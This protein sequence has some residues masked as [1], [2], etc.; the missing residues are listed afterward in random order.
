MEKKGKKR[1]GSRVTGPRRLA[2]ARPRG[3]SYTRDKCIHQLFEAQADLAPDHVAVVCE[4]EQL[5]YAQLN[6]CANQLADRLRSMG[7]GPEVL[8]AIYVERS[9]EMVIGILATLKAG[10]AYVPLDP[11][12][13]KERIAFMFQDAQVPVV[14]TQSKLAKELAQHGAQIVTLD[15]DWHAVARQRIDNMV[16]GVLPDNLA[17]VIYTSGSTGNPKG[18]MITHGN[19]C[20]YVHA[21]RTPLGVGSDTRYLHTATIAFSSSVRQFMLPLTQGAT[22]VIATSSRITDPLKLFELI[23]EQRVTVIDIV[24]SYWRSCIEALVRVDPETRAR[25]L[26]NHLNLIVSASEPLLSDLPRTWIFGFKHGARLINMFGQTETTGIVAVYPIPRV[27]EESVRIVSIGKAIAH[28]DLHILGADLKPVP[29]GQQGELYIGG[30]GLGRG[31]LRR[32]E[33]TAEK[34]IPDPF[35]SESGRRLYKTGD[36][37]RVRQDG[38]IEFLGRGDNQV[39]IRGFRVELPEVE[40]TLSQHPA[41]RQAVV[42]AREVQPGENRLFAYIVPRSKIAPQGSEF[43]NFLMKI[44]PEYMVPGTFVMLDALPLT[45]TGKVDRRALPLPDQA[46]P[47]VRKNYVRPRNRTEEKLTNIWEQVLGVQPIGVEDNYFDLGGH[48]LLAIRLFSEIKKAFGKD[49]PVL[50][51]FKA[52]TI[53]Q[54]AALLGSHESMGTSILVPIRP[55]GSKPPLFL[56]HV[57]GGNLLV[58]GALA[59]YMDPGQPLYGLQPLGMNN[60]QVLHTRVETMAP[61]YIREIRALQAHGPYYLG[62]FS[63]GGKVAFEIARQLRNEGEEIALLAL[64]DT[65]LAPPELV[66]EK[67]V[68][69]TRRI[70]HH[71]R[72][73][74]MLPV[75]DEIYYLKERLKTVKKVV[76]GETRREREQN[77]YKLDDGVPP[78]VKKAIDAFYQ[79][80]RTYNPKKFDGRVTLFRAKDPERGGD[81]RDPTLGWERWAQKGVE[82]HEVPGN[83][84]S[85]I[86]EPHVQVLGK[87]LSACLNKAQGPASGNET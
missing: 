21:M 17:Y 62:G 85:M 52:P 82:I 4:G 57:L 72:S 44:L 55:H 18:V 54:L 79:A 5:T 9:L 87:A 80:S 19:V 36:R 47:L 22:L 61:E 41:V 8:V 63:F 59:R 29:V 7:V 60:G 83:H 13:P 35:N 64:L 66:R 3:I 75:R 32:P 69:F 12:Y 30:Y 68:R 46:N 23:K 40:I 16:S 43:R 38:N 11:A 6:T 49:L 56:M 39:K 14:L 31:Y 34:F 20:H 24:P 33:L 28:T 26:D 86:D 77:T 51:L 50:A 78:S 10:G 67:I 58:Y 84:I 2:E 25:L 65:Y 1:S 27:E 70:R 76:T 73:L 81:R 42:V 71:S 37:A 48:S 74:R 45:P 53:G 15:G